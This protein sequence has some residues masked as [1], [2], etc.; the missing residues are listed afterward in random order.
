MTLNG[1]VTCEF[2]PL[3]HCDLHKSGMSCKKGDAFRCA[4]AVFRES[5]MFALQLLWDS[6]FQSRVVEVLNRALTV[7]FAMQSVWPKACF[8]EKVSWK[9]LVLEVWILVKV[10]WKMLVF[11]ENARFGGLNC[12]FW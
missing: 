6:Q 11:V 7:G 5:D 2:A 12:H 8:C 4:G 1:C 9:M 10:S 3:L